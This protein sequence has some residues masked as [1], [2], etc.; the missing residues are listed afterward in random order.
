MGGLHMTLKGMVQWPNMMELLLDRYLWMQAAFEKA[1]EEQCNLV[2]T[3]TQC[4]IL[5]RIEKHGLPVV[6]KTKN[7][8]ITRQDIHKLIKNLSAKDLIKLY[9]MEN[10]KK[11]R[12]IALTELG[13]ECYDIYT[14]IHAHIEN[15][16]AAN[17]GAG[18][19]ESLKA[20]LQSDWGL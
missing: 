15:Q 16:I 20:I 18:E 12:C 9:H 6:R 11:E 17:I 7:Y 8:H 4:K 14:N 5:S 13:H 3:T 10:N 19:M 1:W 2:I